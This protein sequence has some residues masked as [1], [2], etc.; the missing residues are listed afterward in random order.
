MGLSAGMLPRLEMVHRMG[1]RGPMV[2]AAGQAV[3]WLER[4][5]GEKV[6]QWQFL[7]NELAE[8]DKER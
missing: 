1:W 3:A 4:L 6:I 5:A 7:L 2:P 8:I